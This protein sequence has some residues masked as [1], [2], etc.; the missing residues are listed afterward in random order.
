MG[1]VACENCGKVIP[2]SDV[3][4][5]DCQ[6]CSLCTDCVAVYIAKDCKECE[7]RG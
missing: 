5:G 4:R 7:K 6:Q 1:N 2:E 3:K